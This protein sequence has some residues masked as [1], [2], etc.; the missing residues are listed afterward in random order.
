MRISKAISVKY[1]D[2]L[3]YE[4]NALKPKIVANVVGEESYMPTISILS[5]TRKKA[6]K[7]GIHILKDCLKEGCNLSVKRVIKS[8]AK[9]KRKNAQSGGKR[10]N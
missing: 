1:G 2:G 10:G 8:K 4:E 6:L 3:M 5:L 7:H 9:R